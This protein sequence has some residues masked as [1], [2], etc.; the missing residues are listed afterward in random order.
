MNTD[1][2]LTTETHRTQMEAMQRTHRLTLTVNQFAC[3][4]KSCMSWCFLYMTL[5]FHSVARKKLQQLIQP[6]PRD[7]PSRANL[8]SEIGEDHRDGTWK[9]RCFVSRCCTCVRV[10]V[11]F[12]RMR[13][14]KTF[15]WHSGPSGLLQLHWP[16]DQGAN[17]SE[18]DCR[19]IR[20]PIFFR[21]VSKAIDFN[22]VLITRVKC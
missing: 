4:V 18:Q 20:S 15:L 1:Q 11:V 6:S 9:F 5:S 14:D 21:F 8:V 10:H 12:A 3:L 2:S 19:Y 16:A 22:P 7:P 17:L 13:D